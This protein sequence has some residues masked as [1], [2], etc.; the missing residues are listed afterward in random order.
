VDGFDLAADFGGNLANAFHGSETRH[1][2][3][4]FTGDIRHPPEESRA[5]AR[6]LLAAGAQ[7]SGVEIET[8][9]GHDAVTGEEPAFEAALTGF[10]DS[11]AAARGLALHGGGA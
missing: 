9:R 6:A 3:V 1:C 10:I 4:S 11:A 8:T 5:I 7:V 2:V